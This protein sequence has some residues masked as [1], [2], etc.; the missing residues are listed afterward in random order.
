MMSHMNTPTPP[1]TEEAPKN[2]HRR[3]PRN[4]D[5]ASAIEVLRYRATDC[6]SRT[7]AYR[8]SL[9]T[10]AIFA[11]A[12]LFVIIFGG[13]TVWRRVIDTYAISDQVKAVEEARTAV[14]SARNL[15]RNKDIE[16]AAANGNESNLAKKMHDLRASFAISSRQI[17]TKSKS[18]LAE[19]SNLSGHNSKLA[20]L[21]GFTETHKRLKAANKEVASIRAEME[22]DN[23]EL[24]RVSTGLDAANKNLRNSRLEAE[25]HRRALSSLDTLSDADQQATDSL[26]EKLN[27]IRTD[28]NNIQRRFRAIDPTLNL[29][30][31][32]FGMPKSDINGTDPYLSREKPPAGRTKG[33]KIS[34]VKLFDVTDRYPIFAAEMA[35]AKSLAG[36]HVEASQQIDAIKKRAEQK[37][38][39]RR[40]KISALVTA[41][42]Q[43]ISQEEQAIEKLVSA[44]GLASVDVEQS[45]GRLKAAEQKAA[46]IQQIFDNI[47]S[48]LSL[49]GNAMRRI[50]TLEKEQT[51]L[52]S[53]LTF[54]R[55]QE[56]QTQK[57]LSA[58]QQQGAIIKREY[59]TAKATL[60]TK[61]NEQTV[62][63]G[64]LSEA[65]EDLRIA[66]KRAADITSQITRGAA[67]AGAIGILILLIQNFSLAI[68]YYS[69]LAEI[70]HSQANALIASG[71]DVDDAY[72]FIEKL[73]PLNV[74]WGKTPASL[75]E[76]A[77][78]S[79]AD[80]AK[81][82]GKSTA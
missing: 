13:E 32:V 36:Q 15:E 23:G 43:R 20:Q 66:Q 67:T 59:E 29:I 3:D 31:P 68:R 70:Y 45:G 40:P 11:V 78:S 7:K 14:Q 73:S 61:T 4:V 28:F 75:Y 25:T 81:M 79:L 10:T 27:S 38:R 57:S 74:E 2:P 34:N 56:T 72:E 26:F 50:D 62:K 76:K 18:V 51:S 24:A 49:R 47:N 58:A 55:E 39:T 65:K 30:I 19:K 8:A 63:Q 77:I 82:K 12:F 46:S 37:S 33:Q 41:A 21:G 42:E 52:E 80:V 6:E 44:M 17:E 22:K 54:D 16:L 9:R 35:R 48:E 1:P 53:K 69:R 60:E 71:G 64:E 5:F